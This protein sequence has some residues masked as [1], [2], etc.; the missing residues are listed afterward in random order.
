[1]STDTIPFSCVLTQEQNRKAKA[2]A[3]YHNRSMRKQIPLMI[4]LEYEELKQ[5]FGDQK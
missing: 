3:K 2:I 5:K 4:E 1:M